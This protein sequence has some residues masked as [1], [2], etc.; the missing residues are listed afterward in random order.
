MRDTGTA[1]IGKESIATAY[2][3]VVPVRPF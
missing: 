1:A 2:R 3:E